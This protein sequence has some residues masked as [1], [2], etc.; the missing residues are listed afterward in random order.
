MHRADAFRPAGMSLHIPTRPS[1][2]CTGCGQPW[3]C[4]TRRDQLMAEYSRSRVSLSLYLSSCLVEATR[5][6]PGD[7]AGP[8]YLR[9][10]G[11]LR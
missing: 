3:P 4:A 5:D 10:L 2:N 7:D 1:W 9:F 8:L 6:L 11:W